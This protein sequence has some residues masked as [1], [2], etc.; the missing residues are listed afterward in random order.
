MSE[1]KWMQDGPFGVM[2][3]Y[4]KGIL[5][6]VGKA[7]PDF[8]RMVEQFD[9]PRFADALADCGA[10]W[11]FF[12]IGQNEGFYCSPNAYLQSLLPDVKVCSDRDLVAEMADAVHARGMK[13]I[14]YLPSEVD[15]NTDA[16]RQALAWDSGD[17][18][19]EAFQQRYM[20]VI[21]TW[22]LQ[23][24]SRIDGWF[25]DG[26]YDSKILNFLRS[27]DWD[28]TRFDP[29]QWAQACRAGNAD[30]VFTMNGGLG[31]RPPI[32][33]D[34]DYVSG[35]FNDLSFWPEGPTSFG[36]QNH[37]LIWIDC[38]WMH[39][40]EQGEIVPPR[41]NDE[42]LFNFV[43]YHRHVGSA[44]TLNLGIYEDGQLAEPSL[45][46]LRRLNAHLA[47]ERMPRMLAS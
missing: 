23:H 13:F 29:E 4:I 7:D 1:I 42:R 47:T 17:P 22:A 33:P 28:N 8:N 14:A 44:V 35:E 38:C 27:N 11:L 32:L 41:F 12:T 20:Q 37:A 39:N 16:L 15:L 21:R 43:E 6:R 18:G 3:H 24:G 36:M 46:Q 26:C 40:Q 34:Q 2:V 5:P 30:A 45:A 9:V 19:R 31:C 25:F 10:K